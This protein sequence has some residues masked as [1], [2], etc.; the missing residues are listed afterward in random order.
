[1]AEVLTA[2]TQVILP[3]LRALRQLLDDM[4]PAGKRLGITY[5]E[6][7]VM[8]D[9]AGDARSG[10]F[11]AEML[12]MFCREQAS[13][14]LAVASYFQPIT[15]GA[16]KVE[17]LTCELEPDG[18]VFVMYGAHQGNRL[19]ETPAPTDD[20]DL[21]LCASL[22]PDGKRIYVTVVNRSTASARTLDLSLSNLALADAVEAK[23]LIPSTFEA[24][25]RFVQRDETIPVINGHRVSITLPPCAVGRLCL[26]ARL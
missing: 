9:R 11:A 10:V 1:M 19:L 6:W 25:A 13:L 2:P 4:A 3:G 16:I 18:Q 5:Y 7:N 24:G 23:L 26:G 12:H 22:T 20:A 21:D 15:E 17:P 8:W 14:G